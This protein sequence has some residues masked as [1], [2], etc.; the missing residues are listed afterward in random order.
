MHPDR[1]NANTHCRPFFSCSFADLAR[2]NRYG[3]LEE[4]G[5]GSEA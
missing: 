5:G 4:Q 1:K 2:S 3:A